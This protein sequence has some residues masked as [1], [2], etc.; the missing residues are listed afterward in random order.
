MSDSAARIAYDLRDIGDHL[1]GGTRVVQVPLSEALGARLDGYVLYDDNINSGLQSLNIVASWLGAELT[2]ELALGEEHVQPL[3]DSLAEEMRRKLLGVIF[4]VATEGAP[5][6][7]R[8]YLLDLLGFAGGNVF[9]QASV[10]VSHRQR[11]FSGEDSVFQ[12]A[13]KLRLRD[14]VRQVAR[15]MFVNEGKGEAEAERRCLGDQG[16]EA[17]VVFPYNCPTMTVPV[18]WMSGKYSEGTW[19]PLVERGRRWDPAGRRLVGEDA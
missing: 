17:M 8:G 11:V 4:A 6:R 1:A 3:H 12:H 13:G 5:E 2:P 16:A 7:L 15:E 14:Y 10:I 9:I 18:L 19:E